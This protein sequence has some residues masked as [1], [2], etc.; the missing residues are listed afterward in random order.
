ML[1]QAFF[2]II[3]TGIS[4]PGHGRELVH[5]INFIEKGFLFQL[6]SSVQLP[7]ANIYDTHTVMHTGTRT[8]DVSLTSE[9][10]KPLTPCGFVCGQQNGKDGNWVLLKNIFTSLCAISAS[11]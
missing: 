5:G 3:G 11:F 10:Q 1:S 6:I 9:L 8:F 4:E 2:V 7:G